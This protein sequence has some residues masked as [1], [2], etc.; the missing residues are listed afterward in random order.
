MKRKRCCMCGGRFG[1]IRHRFDFR[2]FCS[3]TMRKRCKQ[4]Y[5]ESL[6]ASRH[7]SFYAQITR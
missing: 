1:L 2:Q 7:A 3:N 5:I 4:R 6:E